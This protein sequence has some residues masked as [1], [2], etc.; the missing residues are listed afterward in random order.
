MFAVLERW[1]L[2]LRE[3]DSSFVFIIFYITSPNHRRLTVALLGLSDFLCFIIRLSF[4]CA[5]VSASCL[6]VLF[7]TV[8][9]I[10]LI[11]SCAAQNKINDWLIDWNSEIIHL[12]SYENGNF[13]N[14]QMW[15]RYSWSVDRSLNT[16]R[17]GTKFGERRSS[18]EEFGRMFCSVRLGNMWLFGR[19]S[20]KIRRHFCGVLFPP[21]T[22]TWSHCRPTSDIV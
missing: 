1:R 15:G 10:Y 3:T 12:T 11:V 18:A 21:L 2:Q 9:C 7:D 22:L 20:A 13:L 16:S 5:P 4:G 17:D 6:C 8:L 14:G 19:T